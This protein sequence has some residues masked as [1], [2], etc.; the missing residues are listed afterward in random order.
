VDIIQNE[1]TGLLVEPDNVES[2]ASAL[3]RLLTDDPLRNRLG[4][5][6][7]TYAQESYGSISLA[8]KFANIVDEAIA[9]KRAQS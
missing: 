3:Y 4:T 1:Q 8:R 7:Y 9:V 5:A 6:G 2:L